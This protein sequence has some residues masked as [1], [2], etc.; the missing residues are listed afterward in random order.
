M[1]RPTRL[2]SNLLLFFVF[3]L[4]FA[5]PLFAQDT[6]TSDFTDNGD[7]TVTHQ[8]TGL[9]WMR[10]AL[11]QTW[12]G[13]T[14]SGTA[15]SYTYSAALTLTSNFAGYS[16]WRLPNIAELQTIVERSNVNPAINTE[17]F[18]NTLSNN[19]FR[20]STFASL[21]GPGSIGGTTW[22]VSFFGGYVVKNDGDFAIAVRLVRSS[23]SSI[24]DLATPSTEF[25]NHRN[26]TV[27]HQRTQ[28]MWQRCAMGATWTGSTCSGTTGI[29]TYDAASQ[30]TSRFA[31]YTDWRLPTATE[32]ASLVNYEKSQPSINTT[33]FPEPIIRY[34]VTNGPG[35]Q[36]WSSQPDVS[37]FSDAWAVDFTFGVVYSYG[38]SYAIP[39]RLVRVDIGSA[40]LTTS[41]TPSTNR[42]Q[43]NQALTYT[44]TVSNI[45]NMDAANATLIVYFPPRGTTY[46]SASAGCVVEGF[47]Y[48]CP[49]GNL[50][51]GASLSRDITVSYTRRGAT[52]I[53]ALGIMDNADKDNSNNS[54][55]VI[56]TITR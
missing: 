35:F 40:D 27:T 21:Q 47:S 55:E 50:A 10:C 19:T 25:T 33:V 11:G 26:G 3:L 5:T 44:A 1:K 22:T 24:I 7:G 9:T 20:S 41:L 14:C 54:S 12:T 45:G 18:P 28:L 30:L 4:A 16:D 49:L 34:P 23:Q 37:D 38:R 48:R 46:L 31:G 51:A 43:L 6:P 36:Y 52:N 29:Y 42:V 53:T 2:F 8:K 56:T 17:L 39:V 15:S 32:L 13:S